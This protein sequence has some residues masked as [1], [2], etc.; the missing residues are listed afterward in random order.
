MT[1]CPFCDSIDIATKAKYKKNPELRSF[2]VVYCRNCGARGPKVYTD[3]VCMNNHVASDYHAMA[4]QD[5]GRWVE[6]VVV[7]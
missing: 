2:V 4:R 6:R 1:P 7:L 5:W 3:Q